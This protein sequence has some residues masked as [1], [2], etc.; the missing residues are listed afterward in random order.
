MSWA[1]ANQRYL[2]AALDVVRELLE[3]HAANEAPGAAPELPDAGLVA[4]REAAR[5]AM[6]EPPALEILAES[7]GLSAFERDVVLL[8]AGPD[9]D[10]A[11][12]AACAPHPSFSLALAALPEAHWSALGP[13]APLRRWRLIELGAG[14][15]LTRRPLAVDERVL[16]YLAGVDDSSDHRLAGWIEPLAPADQL[17]PSQER[18]AE[19]LA[20]AWTEP[21]GPLPVVELCG[22][23]PG[24]KR[25]VASAA[26]AA[27][28]LRL[29]VLPALTI[30]DGPAELDGLRR[31][32]EREAVLAGGA[33]LVD[34]EA[35][36]TADAVRH[37]ALE[38]FLE[39][40]RG[41][42]IL[43]AGKRRRLRQRPVVT[44]DVKRPDAAE[45]RALW[46]SVL[47]SADLN[48]HVDRLVGQ[49]DL[50]AA[51]IRAIGAELAAPDPGALWDVARRHARPRLDDLGQRIEPR[52][53]WDDLVLPERQKATLE[54]IATHVRHR[55]K[56]YEAWGFAAKS[57]RGLGI[58]A[59][60]TGTS[61][62]GKTMASEVLAGALELDLYRIDLS[63]VISKYIGE[64]E[65]NLKK[66]FDAA[67]GGGAILLF[68]EADALF[69]KRSEVKDSHDRYANIEVSYLLQRMEAY[70]GLAILTSN[71]KDA[72]DTAFLRR[73]RFAVRFPFPDA[74]QR[75]EIWRR[76]FPAQTPTEGLDVERLSRLAVAGGNIRNIA[77]NG[78]FLAAEEDVAVAMR[79]LARAARSEL[80]KIEKPLSESELKGWR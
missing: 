71:Q 20:A 5:A 74:V 1:E 53:S 79:H 45:Q 60:F 50:D 62:T 36:D 33:L 80:A 31:L 46:H 6:E 10:G 65:K 40:T 59:L 56:V 76:I 23:D 24:A 55:L 22:D 14:S 37:D 75:A 54:E 17:V 49:L 69:G 26:C 25:A 43:A 57:N 21:E 3:R 34:A 18:L 4:A 29:Y 64:T 66:V 44:L 68:D 8:A 41:A 61:G 77:M 38:R 27:F 52:A 51:T 47:D 15:S 39:S 67:E 48:G 73:I 42:L 16:H 72:L 32:W 19:R 63:A 35:L 13:R 28:G 70:R 7:F 2:S 9:L 30:P 12:A 78:A 11:F 58:S